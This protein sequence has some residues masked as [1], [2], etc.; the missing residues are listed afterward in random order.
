[1]LVGVGL[2]A[3]TVLFVELCLIEFLAWFHRT[4]FSGLENRGLHVNQ[5][6]Y[7]LLTNA[8]SGAPEGTIRPG[9]SLR[10]AI[11]AVRKGWLLSNNDAI[12][13]VHTRYDYQIDPVHINSLQCLD[14]F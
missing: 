8:K 1:M 14:S 5:D 6:R 10:F 11:R 4:R 2:E 13:Q 7:S 12:P 3:G 9:S